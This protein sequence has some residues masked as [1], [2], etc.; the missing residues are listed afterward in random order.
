MATDLK[1]LHLAELHER[2][3]AAGIDGYRR[4]RRDELIERLGEAGGD[5]ADDAV[6]RRPRRQGR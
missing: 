2:A 3:A 6:E 1:D 5:D 4:L